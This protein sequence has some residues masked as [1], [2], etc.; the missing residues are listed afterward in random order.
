M[1]ERRTSEVSTREINSTPIH[2]MPDFQAAIV[3]Y[4]KILEESNVPHTDIARIT[5]EIKSNPTRRQ[6]NN[7]INFVHG[8][9]RKKPSKI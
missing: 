4:T 1:K 8:I 5:N 2:K 7:F 9:S 6:S 3:D